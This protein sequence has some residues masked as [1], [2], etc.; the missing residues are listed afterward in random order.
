MCIRDRTYTFRNG[1]AIDY[2]GYVADAAQ[3]LGK[4]RK[5]CFLVKTLFKNIHLVGFC[6]KSAVNGFGFRI[7]CGF[8]SIV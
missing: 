8:E 4:N 6:Q 5:H 3:A 1:A 2:D 7:V